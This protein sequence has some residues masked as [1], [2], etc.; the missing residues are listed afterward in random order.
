MPVAGTGVGV[1]T[2][3]GTVDP[4]RAGLQLRCDAFGALSIFAEDGA[5]Q[6]VLEAVDFGDRLSVITLHAASEK[7]ASSPSHQ[8]GARAAPPA[9]TSFPRFDYPAC[10]IPRSDFDF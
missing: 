1:K 9:R 7:W 10:H 4:H 3:A 2:D 6:A 5:S 8:P